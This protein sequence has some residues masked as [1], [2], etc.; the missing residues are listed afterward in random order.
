MFKNVFKCF[1]RSSQIMLSI[2]RWNWLL[3]FEAVVCQRQPTQLLIQTDDEDQ[4]RLEVTFTSSLVK[5]TKLKIPHIQHLKIV[6]HLIK[7]VNNWQ[8]IKQSIPLISLI[9]RCSAHFNWVQYNSMEQ[10]WA[11]LTLIK[12]ETHPPTPHRVVQIINKSTRQVKMMMTS[13][14]ILGHREAR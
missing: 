10:C 12:R 3:E 1:W 7:K 14:R 8:T 4:S 11:L 6:T 2:F 5:K 9:E 13:M